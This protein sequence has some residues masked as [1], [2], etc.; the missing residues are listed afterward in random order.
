M[1]LTGSE[2]RKMIKKNKI[3]IIPFNEKHLN[4]NSYNYRLGDFYR[5]VTVN[6]EGETI[7]SEIKH[8]KEDGIVLMPNRLYLATTNE[9]IGSSH[10]VTSL[11]GRSSLGRLGLFLQCSADLGNLGESHKWTL[12]LKCVQPIKIYPSMIIGQVSFWEPQG[13]ISLYQGSYTHF[14]TP[15][16]RLEA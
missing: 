14:N 9:I 8:I 15:E 6:E 16:G 2:I 10:Y 3:D 1:I 7:T 4:P 13:D 11:I 5:E 12:E